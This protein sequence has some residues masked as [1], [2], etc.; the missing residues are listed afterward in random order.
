V[1]PP[2]SRLSNAG[3]RWTGTEVQPFSPL[4][5]HGCAGQEGG[6]RILWPLLYALSARDTVLAERR[7]GARLLAPR[8]QD[9]QVRPISAHI[10]QRLLHGVFK[11]LVVFAHD[12]A[13]RSWS[14]RDR[15]DLQLVSMLGHVV[16]RHGGVLIAPIS[17]PVDDLEDHEAFVGVVDNFDWL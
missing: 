3:A 4:W 16:A 9:G 13:L 2:G 15:T 1:W 5:Y 11:G 8:L 14:H 10:G 12:D 7:I 17:G 6:Q